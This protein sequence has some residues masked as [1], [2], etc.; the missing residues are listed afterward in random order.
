M[1]MWL[2]G[3]AELDVWE[4]ESAHVTTPR[5]HVVPGLTAA[6]KLRKGIK[7][8]HRLEVGPVKMMAALARSGATLSPDA[9]VGFWRAAGAAARFQEACTRSGRNMLATAGLIGH[10]RDSTRTALA[11]DL[12]QAFTWLLAVE[13]FKNTAVV[14]FGRGCSLLSPAV[15]GPGLGDQRPDFMASSVPWTKIALFESKGTIQT[16][17]DEVQ[18]RDGLAGGLDQTSSGDRWLTAHG[19]AGVVSQQLAVSFALVEQPCSAAAFADP[20]D[21]TPGELPAS[22]RLALVRAHFGAW[23]AAGGGV[24]LAERLWH[25]EV[26]ASVLEESIAPLPTVVLR[27]RPMRLLMPDEP[28]GG[29]PAL[30]F[31]FFPYP[32]YAPTLHLV[33]EAVLQA[34]AT[35]ELDLIA[36]SIDAFRRAFQEPGEENAEGARERATFADGTVYTSGFDSDLSFRAQ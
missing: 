35:G 20:E 33:D 2:H 21:P 1:N 8:R 15:P 29:L 18:W 12:G 23:A 4:F 28:L 3:K 13:H 14:D 6:G 5:T 17:L 16:S 25:P 26:A 36:E 11:G 9:T 27:N 22:S 10:L 19:Q 34:V 30:R 7:H 31:P 24:A 32:L